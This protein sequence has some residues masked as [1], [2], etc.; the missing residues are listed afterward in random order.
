M[1]NSSSPAGDVWSEQ[2]KN[3]DDVGLRSA[4]NRAPAW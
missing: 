4:S 1:N 3:M 2:S